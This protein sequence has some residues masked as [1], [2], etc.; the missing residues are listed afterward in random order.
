VTTLLS[1][2]RSS[3][4]KLA[5]CLLTS[6]LAGPARGLAEPAQAAENTTRSATLEQL[7]RYTEE[8]SP[9]LRVARSQRAR[10][11]AAQVRADVLLPS[12]PELSVAMGPRFERAPT[13]VDIEASLMQELEISGARGAR[14]QAAVRVHERTEAEIEQARWELTC[15][16]RETFRRA[17]VEQ[18]RVAL[19][20]QVL[21][22][23]G[24]VLR[25]V[26]RQIHAGEIG[27]LSL[28]L[29]QAEVAQSQQL[30][31]AADQSLYA[32]RLRLSQLSGWPADAPPVVQGTL[33]AVSDP[34]D[35]PALVKRA[36]A[37]LPQLRASVARAREAEAQL[38]VADREGWPKPSVGVQYQR[39]SNRAMEGIYNIVMGAV[40]LP[41]PVFQT[42]QAAR[43]EARA[44]LELAQAEWLAQSQLLAAQVASA[45]S[46]LVAAAGRMQAYRGEILPHFEENLRLLARSFE[47]GEID[48]LALSAARERFLQ[49]QADA[50]HAQREYSIALSTLERSIGQTLGAAP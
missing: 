42:N 20:R 50:L 35:L 45:R 29:A 12:N 11:R 2:C 19:E 37:H 16:V 43:A 6:V 7:L 27:P 18:Q 9:V 5:L 46:E 4:R 26:E 15:D 32:L 36:H 24:E 44:E 34:P 14:R 10:A 13:G 47:L 8:H 30:V 3:T 22:F 17:L 23:Q 38:A 48:L 31:A 21:G 1:H 25:V 28:R 41:I 49:I 39:E 40:S 33:E